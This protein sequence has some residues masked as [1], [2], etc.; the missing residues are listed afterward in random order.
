MLLS[1]WY[2]DE[3]R[4]EGRRFS[5]PP[6]DVI[7]V[8]SIQRVEPQPA[9]TFAAADAFAPPDPEMRRAVDPA[10]ELIAARH[11][12]AFAR[13]FF[14]EQ[15]ESSTGSGFQN[16]SQCMNR[17]RRAIRLEHR[18]APETKPLLRAHRQQRNPVIGDF[19]R[20]AVAQRVRRLMPA[21]G[22]DSSSRRRFC[23]R[24]ASNR[25]SGRSAGLS[26]TVQPPRPDWP[27]RR[28]GTAPLQ[29]VGSP[30]S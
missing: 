30:D 21:A 8:F 7:L 29:S 12:D 19:R 14:F 1:C 17:F 5:R 18:A 3:L 11:A 24:Y 9:R 6:I 2:G 4:A 28:A 22:G 15:F 26:T 25:L 13:H 10:R 27:S 23:S 20:K 16:A